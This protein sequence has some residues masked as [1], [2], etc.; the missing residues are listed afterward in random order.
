MTLPVQQSCITNHPLLEGVFPG[1]ESRPALAPGRTGAWTRAGTGA[2]GRGAEGDQSPSPGLG[3][4]YLS[5]FPVTPSISSAV[6]SGSFL[7]VM[8]GHCSE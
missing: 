1:R 7:R 3:E 5:S 6:G 4:K 2:A 8:T